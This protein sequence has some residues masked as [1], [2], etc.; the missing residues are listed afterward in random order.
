MKKYILQRLGIA[1]ITIFVV[2]TVTF[3]LMHSIP[4]T[5]FTTGNDN[6]TAEA[7]AAMEANYGLDKP[8]W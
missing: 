7:L 1:V 3:F 2:I 6:M 8:L 5:P 4:G